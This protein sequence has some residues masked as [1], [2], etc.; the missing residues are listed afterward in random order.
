M[1]ALS[2]EQASYAYSVTDRGAPKF[3]LGPVSFE[4]QTARNRRDSRPER[5]RQIDAAETC[6]PDCYKPLS[7]FVRID[8]FEVSQLDPRD[9]AQ[10]I[11]LV[12][13]ESALL[14]PLRVWEY[15]L[16][17]RYPHGRRLRFESEEDCLLAANAL[18]QVGAGFARSLDGATFRRRKAARDS[19][20]RAGAAAVAAAAR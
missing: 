2:V 14:F 16:Q 9:R 12:Q 8:G 20:A 10:Q 3:A 11:A 19:G 7:G 4:A 18:A 1:C 5:Q 17:G 13:Q 6:S 15:V